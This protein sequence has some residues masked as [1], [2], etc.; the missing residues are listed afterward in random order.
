MVT[1]SQIAQAARALIGT[2]FAHQGRI[3]GIGIDCVGI[4]LLVGEMF[5]LSDITGAVIRGADHNR[6][7]AQPHSDVVFDVCTKRL[8]PVQEVKVGCVLALNCMTVACH[9]AIVTAPLGFLHFVHANQHLGKV[10]ETPLDAKWRRR[11]KGIF[12]FPGTTD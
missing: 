9:A 5:H 12:E 6:Y 4:P 11:I 8:I 1:R 3:P 7:T 10:V 2:P